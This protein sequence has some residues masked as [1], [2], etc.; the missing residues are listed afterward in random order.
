MLT[1]VVQCC[2]MLSNVVQC[3]PMLSNIAECCPMLANV[4]QCCPMLSNV[5]QCC[6]ILARCCPMLYNDGENAHKR[7]RWR[8]VDFPNWHVPQIRFVRFAPV[9]V[10]PTFDNKGNPPTCGVVTTCC[11]THPVLCV[12]VSACLVWALC[13]HCT[14]RVRDL[15]CARGRRIDMAKAMAHGVVDTPSCT[16]R[17]TLQPRAW[18]SPHT[19]GDTRTHVGARRVRHRREG[20]AIR[21]RCVPGL[22][23]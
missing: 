2:P 6:P 20:Y 23:N 21:R 15:S 16:A 19:R 3:C 14:L 10:E 5:V 17:C 11:H 13:T 12:W 1:N 9:L 22:S 7:V 4:G 8:M 18:I